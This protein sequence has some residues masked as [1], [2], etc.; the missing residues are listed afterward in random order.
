MV[1]KIEVPTWD[2]L[3]VIGKSRIVELTV[4]VPFI[5]YLLLFNNEMISY[6]ELSSDIISSG[7]KIDEISK[8]TISRLYFLYFGLTVLGFS[9]MA[10]SIKCPAIIK[11][12]AN[13]YE[14]LATE[15]SIITYAKFATL[16]KPFE[17]KLKNSPEDYKKLEGFV[18]AYRSAYTDAE[19][20]TLA[21]DRQ[22]IESKAKELEKEAHLNVLSFM[23]NYHIRS[24]RTLRAALSV[25]YGVGFLLLLYPSLQVFVTICT[26]LVEK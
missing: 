6:F 15:L 5:G 17:E 25:G 18:S 4:L 23:W 14:F 8:D 2:A 9:S 3:R 20:I 19:K 11:N 22:I 16:L 21:T 12:H 26:T 1:T 10:F 7:Q 24:M 13:E